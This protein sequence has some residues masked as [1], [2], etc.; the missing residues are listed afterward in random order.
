MECRWRFEQAEVM[1]HQLSDAYIQWIICYAYCGAY[2]GVFHIPCR[3]NLLLYYGAMISE[4][5][6]GWSEDPPIVTLHIHTATSRISPFS[7]C[8]G[9]GVQHL[10]I[11]WT[12]LA[13]IK[14]TVPTY[15]N[16]D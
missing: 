13:L 15:M 11:T 14:Q 6:T 2:Y 5:A 4:D 3:L 8:L 7:C 1:R 12:N 10:P 9:L 16:V